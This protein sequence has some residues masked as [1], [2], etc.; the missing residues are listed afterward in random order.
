M[1]AEN[2]E[3]ARALAVLDRNRDKLTKAN[4]QIREAVAEAKLII[5]KLRAI[6]S[7]IT[8]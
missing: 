2:P 6:G 1:Q 3:L 7:S 8:A 5:A 4:R